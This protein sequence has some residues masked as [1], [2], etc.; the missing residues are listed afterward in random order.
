MKSN[1]SRQQSRA[2]ETRV[3]SKNLFATDSERGAS[4]IVGYV[5]V[6]SLVIGTAASLLIASGPEITAT[7]DRE[8]YDAMERNFERLDRAAQNARGTSGPHQITLSV[9]QGTLRT[10][11]ET[12][13]I[14]AIYTDTSGSTTSHSIETRGM[15]FTA[16]GAQRKLIYDSGL[17]ATVDASGDVSL[18]KTPPAET[19]THGKNITT[20]PLVAYNHTKTRAVT[21]QS[22][23]KYLLEERTTPRRNASTFSTD[24]SATTTI[25]V[26]TDYPLVWEE[27][28][29]QRETTTVVLSTG[30]TVAAEVDTGYTVRISSRTVTVQPQV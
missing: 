15:Q 18:L 19:V 25:T 16:E 12:T 21:G 10:A 17:I 5:L 29:E 13:K 3:A 1:T 23:R 6:F 20:L 28:F 7:Q 30:N 26:E 27:Y 22:R 14:N 9:P 11:N 4:E 8:A 24:G 2:S